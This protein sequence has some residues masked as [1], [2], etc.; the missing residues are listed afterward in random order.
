MESG[1]SG[2]QHPLLPQV[3]GKSGINKTVSQKHLKTYLRPGASIRL[4][5]LFSG[6]NA[7]LTFPRLEKQKQ[8]L[9]YYYIFSP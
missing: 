8:K 1:E 5:I 2:A 4:G 9:S 3:L 6:S 7:C